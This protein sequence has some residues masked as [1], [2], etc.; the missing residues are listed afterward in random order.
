MT[1]DT[2]L[3]RVR[4]LGVPVNLWQKT[5]AHQDAIQREFDIVRASLPTQST[6]HRLLDLIRDLDA[7]F[8]EFGEGARQEVASAVKQGKRQVDLTYLVPT[9]AA[10]AARTVKEM[11]AEV[12]AYCRAGEHLLTLATPDDQIAFRNWALGEFIRQIEHGLEPLPWNDHLTT[13]VVPEPPEQGAMGADE[14]IEF[15][16]DLDLATAGVLRDAIQHG[17]SA[18]V[19]RL[20]VDLTRVGFMDSVGMSLLVATH[21]R[22][23]EDG[24]EMRLIVP[25]RLYALL[26]LTGLTDVLRPEEVAMGDSES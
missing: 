13:K 12:D 23:T 7:R 11:L 22:L 24:V 9:A 1:T 15:E 25:P 21:N 6:P 14:T 16:G 3:V 17:R 20:T 8:G 2:S 5:S 10:H 4:L 26:A 18:S 19:G